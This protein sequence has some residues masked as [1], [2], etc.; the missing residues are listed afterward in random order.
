MQYITKSIILSK[1]NNISTNSNELNI[2]LPSVYYAEGAEIALANL[3]IYFSWFNVTSAFNNN[4]YSYLWNGVSFGVTMPDGYYSPLDMTGY[5]QY[6]M[7]QNGHYLQDPNGTN[8]YYMSFIQ[9]AVYYADSVLCNAVPSSLPTNWTNPHNISL[10]GLCPQL[11]VPPNNDFGLLLGYAPGTYPAVQQ[12]TNYS[13]NSS[14]TPE[15]SPI[16]SISVVSNL[17]N[18]G[19]FNSVAGIIGS[20]SSGEVAFGGQIII[21]RTFPVYYAVNDGRHAN[22]SIKFYDDKNRSLNIQ[23]PNIIATL[24]IRTIKK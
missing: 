24:N 15:I 9:N 3:Y 16:T 6:T 22:V 13:S 18:T 11:V 5:L 19:D 2:V 17:A 20:F 21:D 12:N 4:S 10:N 14:F 7:Q 8:V 1:Q 23:D